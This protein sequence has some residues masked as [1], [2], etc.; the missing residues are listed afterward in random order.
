VAER[1]RAR[2]ATV[3]FAVH[4]G[5]VLL[6]RH[7]AG[8]D[9][10]AG[11]WNGIGGH[12]EPGEDVRLAARRELREESGIDAEG[13]S[14]RGVVHETGLLGEAYV[15]FLFVAP[16]ES[17]ALAPEAGAELCWQPLDRLAE[18]QLV[19]DL[20][21]LLPRLLAAGEPVFATERYD[22]GDRRLELAIEGVPV[23]C[24]RRS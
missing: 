15:V 14:L 4:E 7:A 1:H 9:R 13:L 3:A 19:S 23:E 12:V 2:L 22:G 6:K 8:G 10:F 20:P 11:L 17:R 21:A 24:P 18:L 5:R 16:V